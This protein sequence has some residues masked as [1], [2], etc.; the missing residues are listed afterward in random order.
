[1]TAYGAA[2]EATANGVELTFETGLYAGDTLV[3]AYSADSANWEVLAAEYVVFNGNGT[4]TLKLPKLG[5]VAFLVE[6]PDDLPNA[7]QAVSSPE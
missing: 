2:V 6:A 1:M 7:G 5:A 3:V 4:V